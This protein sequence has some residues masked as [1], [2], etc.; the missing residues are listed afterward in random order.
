MYW[1]FFMNEQIVSSVVLVKADDC[2]FPVTSTLN[3]FSVN[4]KLE[5][6]AKRLVH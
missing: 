2:K 1:V 6:K 5:Y 3:L 4:K